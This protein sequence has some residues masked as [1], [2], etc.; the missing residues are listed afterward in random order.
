M[1]IVVQSTLKGTGILGENQ[2]SV[3][4]VLFDPI[5]REELNDRSDGLSAGTT[6]NVWFKV[7]R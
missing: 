6:L 7:L 1:Q 2:P 5:D 3:A 4:L